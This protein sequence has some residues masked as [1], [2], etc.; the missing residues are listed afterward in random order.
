MVVSITDRLRPRQPARNTGDAEPRPADVIPFPT[1]PV[2]LM[3][4]ADRGEQ[5]SKVRQ[6]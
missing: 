5:L 1:N 3:R 6:S 2:V 4:N